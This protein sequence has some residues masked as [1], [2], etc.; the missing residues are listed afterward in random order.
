MKRKLIK[1]GLGAVTITLPIQWVKERNLSAGTEVDVNET[2]EGILISSQFL[3]KEK[4]IT[5]DVSSYND[6]MIMNMIY[7]SY[8]LGYDTIILL[9]ANEEQYEA[10]QRITPT[11]IGFEITERKQNSCV[12]QNIAEPNEDKF[13]IMLRKIFLQTLQFSEEIKNYLTTGNSEKKFIDEKLQIDKLTNYARRA[14]IRTKQGGNKASLLYEIVSKLSIISHGYFYLYE[15]VHKTKKKRVF[16][17]RISEHLTKTNNLLK[18]Y[19]DAFYKKD[20]DELYK[21]GAEKIELF[22]ENNILLESSKGE[23][24]VMLSYIR[25]IIRN[26]QLIATATIGFALP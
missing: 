13:E 5:V 22:K 9:F 3:K 10:I 25:E 2:D 6:R 21:I 16:E 14:I 8:R 1:Q 7:Q 19:Y 11:L 26:I 4:A 12:L 20:L 24:C 23:I 17:K 15:Y 18:K